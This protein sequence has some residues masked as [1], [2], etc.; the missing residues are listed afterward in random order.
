MCHCNPLIKTPYC[1]SKECQDEAARV[2]FTLP[3]HEHN[4]MDQGT[5]FLREQFALADAL[6]EA[7]KKVRA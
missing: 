6:I 4:M 3:P 5:A 2:R 7:R 1:D